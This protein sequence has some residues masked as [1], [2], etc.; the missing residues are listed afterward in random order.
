M[1]PVHGERPIPTPELS[2]QPDKPSCHLWDFMLATAEAQAIGHQPTTIGPFAIEGVLGRG[3]MGVVYRAR[4]VATLDLVAL[5]TVRVPREAMLASIRREIH[6]LSRIRHPGISRIV[7]EG[8]HEGLPWYAMEFYEGDTLHSHIQRCWNGAL[9]SGSRSCARPGSPPSTGV[10]SNTAT[11]TPDAS[12]I[13]TPRDADLSDDAAARRPQVVLEAVRPLLSLLAS[14]CATLAF[15]HGEG[16]VHRDLKPENVFV[17]VDGQPVLVDLG[18]VGSFGGALGREVLAAEGSVLGSI[19]YMAPEQIRGEFV[20]ARAD[21]YALGCMLYECLTGRPP[22]IGSTAPAI[23]YQH[24][25]E[26]PLPPSKLVEGV[27]DALDRLALRLLEKR[28]ED[29]LGFAEDVGET[30]SKLGVAAPVMQD[31]PKAQAYLY[32]PGFEGRQEVVAELADVIACAE[33]DWRGDFILLGGESGVGKTRLA[34][35]IAR[36]AAQQGMLVITGQCVT[37]GARGDGSVVAAP[38]HPFRP[39]LV[40]IADLARAGDAAEVERL[41]GARGKVLAAYEPALA[42]LPSVREQPEPPL[43]P[44]D[45]SRQRVLDSLYDALRALAAERPLLL[46]LDD[47]QW[48][49]ELSLAALAQCAERGF[50]EEPVIVFGTYRIEE[51]SAAISALVRAKGA[52]DIVLQR[53]D[54]ASVGGMVSGMLA[55]REPARDLVE[56]LAAHSDGNPFF[57]AEYLRAAI[58]EGLLTRDRLGQWHMHERAWGSENLATLVPLPRTVAEL[59]E[60]RLGALDEDARTLAEWASVLGREFDSHLLTGTGQLADLALLEGLETLRVRQVLE[61]PTPGRLRFVHDKIRES[62]YGRIVVERRRGLH[63]DAALV[64]EARSADQPDAWPDLGYHFAEALVHDKAALYVG[65]A[66][67]RAREAYANEEA[68]RLYRM[69]I[70]ERE[71]AGAPGASGGELAMPAVDQLLEGLGDVLALTGRQGEAQ[72]A[73]AGALGRM[74]ARPSLDLARLHRKIGKAWETRQMHDEALASF[75]AAEEA[76]GKNP[77]DLQEQWL[78]AWV[79]LQS[80]RIAVYYWANHMK[81]MDQLIARVRPIV[82]QRATPLQRTQF[83]RALIQNN[84]RTERYLLS[85]ETVG[86]ARAC[87]AAHIELGDPIEIASARFSLGVTLL[88]HGSLEEGLAEMFDVLENA[89]RMGHLP[90]QSRC[91]TYITLFYRRRRAVAETRHYGQQSLSIAEAGNMVEYMAAARANLGWVAYCE[92]RKGECLDHCGA[93]LRLW[94]ALPLVYPFQWTARLPLAAAALDAGRLE[95]VLEHL[96]AILDP[97]QQRLPPELTSELEAATGA[98]RPAED[99]LRSALMRA[100]DSGYL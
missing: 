7:D 56:F 48:A 6:A 41:L 42:A 64:I 46:L 94:A 17:R 33:D 75:A 30:L 11:R 86:Y 24:I 16:L 50:G 59:I 32:R 84:V 67:V 35:E 96:R 26:R 8:L 45:A 83:L 99:T 29:R 73:F 43:L 55:L 74:M 2:K 14:L 62:A 63:R 1:D 81:A 52:R 9:A 15:L 49:D 100:M 78:D 37:L 60:R 80:D 28:P 44:P 98:N 27:P 72:A 36:K 3:G 65:R 20:D 97:Q 95:E 21:L 38:L 34:M 23:L 79:Q 13:P 25:S 10:A 31:A 18:V 53:L 71:A 91:L 69:G 77:A 82:E 4:H 54:S 88:W 22:F 70:S 5:K 40:A 68:I 12:I 58:G 19:P 57:V 76:L 51:R 66:A 61:E 87:L 85:I 47:L 39:L 90:L 93:A 92:A 89:Q